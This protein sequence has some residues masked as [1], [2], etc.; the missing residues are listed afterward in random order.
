MCDAKTKFFVLLT[1]FFIS[2]FL[3]SA[4]EVRRQ[5]ANCDLK[6]KVKGHPE[7]LDIAVSLIRFFSVTIQHSADGPISCSLLI[8]MFEIM[9][10]WDT[11]SLVSHRIQR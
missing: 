2:F 10:H 6:N 5:I 9:L 7:D 11:K 3:I 8:S 1:I 4:D